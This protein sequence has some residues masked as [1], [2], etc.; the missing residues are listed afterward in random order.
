MRVAVPLMSMRP[1]PW[2]EREIV[3]VIPHIKLQPS[4]Q[5][6]QAAIYVPLA[7]NPWWAAS[8]VVR[9]VGGPSEA[10]TPAIRAAVARIDPD[11]PLTRVRT[12]DE[13]GGQATERWRFR[14]VLVGGFALLALALAMVGVFGV[15]AYSVQQRT[16]EFGVRMALGA[17]V[18]DVMRLVF[19]SAARTT[20]I[21]TAVGLAGAALVSRSIATLLFDVKPLDPIT[22]AAAAAVLV[23]TAAI[24]TAAPALRAAR[25]DPVVTFR[26]E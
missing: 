10:L 23:V 20:A 4:E 13:V 7:Q 15:L 26:T 1:S 25:V 22:F 2:P 11:V 14:A 12:L 18:A 19:T 17:S 24:A 3:G 8:L 9:P 16:R 5:R 6:P 21:G